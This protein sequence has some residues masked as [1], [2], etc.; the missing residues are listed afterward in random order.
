MTPEH[1]G[2]SDLREQPIGELI[3]QLSQETSTLVRQEVELARAE[4]REKA[5]VAKAGGGMFAGAGLLGLLAA[6]ALT[7]FLIAALAEAMDVW[8]AALIV[9]VIYAVVAGLLARTGKSRIDQAMPAV[10]RQAQDTIKE[11]VEWARTR[12]RSART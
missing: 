10:P 12:A 6:G 1:N 5:R 7:A 11:D 2:S 9:A 4:M 3:K 8:L